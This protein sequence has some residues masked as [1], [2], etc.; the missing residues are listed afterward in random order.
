MAQRTY[1]EAME[2]CAVRPDLAALQAAADAHLTDQ[3][4]KQERL[5]RLRRGTATLV[6]LIIAGAVGTAVAGYWLL[7]SSGG[8][9]VGPFLAGAILTLVGAYVYFAVEAPPPSGAGETPEDLVARLLAD[10]KPSSR[11]ACDRAETASA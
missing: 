9:T 11:A 2:P 7:L 6:M 4:I 10:V 5:A 1:H 3:H 8:R